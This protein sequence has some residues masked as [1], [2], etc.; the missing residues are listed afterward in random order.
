MEPENQ[1]PVRTERPVGRGSNGVRLVP[2][3]DPHEI[4]NLD[5]V[6]IGSQG[7]RAG[8]SVAIFLAVYR[9]F[10]VILGAMAVGFYPPVA[11]YDFSPAT[12][13]VS[14]LV[15]FIAML[16][17]VAMVSLFEHRSIVEFNL[18]GP[19]RPVNFLFGMAAG[20]LAL[21]MLVGTLAFGGWLHFGPVALS[22]ANVVKFAALWGCAF[23][24]VGCVEE[25]IFRCFLQFTLTRGINFWW[26]FGIVGVVC[27]DLLSRSRGQ[28]G[29]IAF[30]W[31]EPLPAVSG[32]G[33][34]GVYAVALLGLAPCL[35]MHLT[36]A[37]GAGF[38]QAAWVT[39]TLFGF[40][41][42]GNNGENW[43]GVFAAAAIGFVFCVSVWVT[44]SA[45]WAIGCHAAWDWAETYFYGTA[46]SGLASKGHFL[47]TSPV[48]NPLWSGGMAGP[49]GSLLVLGVILL[50]L[51]ALL[52]IYGRGRAALT[53]MEQQSA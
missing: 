36:R 50:L 53:V 34:W 17:A 20:F 39:S 7:L 37:M 30:L 2:D 41:H 51:M 33:V 6:L 40:V 14:E 11:R 25:G 49:E 32:N 5:W 8:W 19:R 38:W 18:N 44:G 22:G 13:L 28:V 47:S 43:I 4:R 29:I 1:T 16:G 35:R 52:V 45:W 48:G 15:P 42:T 10:A 12:A 23:L 24:L 31:V 3:P 46:D 26:A 21:S 27:L 9:L